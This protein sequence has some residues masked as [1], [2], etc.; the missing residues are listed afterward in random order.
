MVISWRVVCLNHRTMLPMG[1]V[2]V[3]GKVMWL[4]FSWHW[5]FKHSYYYYYGCN[6][7]CKYSVL[8]Q[9][10]CS[11]ALFS[12]FLTIFALHCVFIHPVYYQSSGER[13]KMSRGKGQRKG[14]SNL[15]HGIIHRKKNNLEIKTRMTPCM[16]IVM[17]IYTTI[18]L[19]IH[20]VH[21]I[22]TNYHRT[23]IKARWKT[24]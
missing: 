5:K 6:V 2:E 9:T 7:T 15:C 3:K 17:V 18:L 20:K 24:L 16:Y 1:C 12:P 22:F 4:Y 14:S 8:Y 10:Y 13:G 19:H 11:I 23:T 21:K